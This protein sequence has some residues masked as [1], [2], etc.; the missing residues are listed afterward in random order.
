MKN[1]APAVALMM[2][3]G[4][5]A[6]AP[7]ISVPISEIS[8]DDSVAPMATASTPA[9]SAWRTA[10]D[11]DRALRPQIP[12]LVSPPTPRVGTGI[13]LLGKGGAP[14]RY[15][16]FDDIAPQTVNASPTP[17]TLQYDRGP[18][19]VRVQ[20]LLDRANFST[21]VID[22][23]MAKNTQLAIYWFQYSQGL[24]PTGVINPETYNRLATVAGTDRV[25]APSIIDQQSLE[26][27]FVR[28][29]QSVYAQSRLECMCYS[30]P[31]ELLAERFHTTPEVL[32]KLNPQTGFASLSAG[33]FIWAP[34][35][36]P[37]QNS[38]EKPVA[39]IHISK[40]GNYVQA[41]AADGSIVLHFPS[42]LGSMYDPSPD[43]KFEVIGVARYPTF[44]YDPKL[45]S[46]VP[47]TKP[48]AK[49]PP[50]P[51]SPVGTVWIALSK[52]HVGIHGTPTPETIGSASSHGCVRLTNWDAEKL[53]GATSEG[54]PVE[55]VL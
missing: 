23:H 7:R 39:R 46:D 3:L 27:P 4:A 36:Q 28:I 10:A 49:L 53:A 34:S 26:G 54:T 20:V 6:C 29:P 13:E 14:V 25:I 22:G 50:G 38:Q 43:G 48:K 31:I 19:V 8:P 12:A 24:P 21:G 30:S 5:A 51:N 41:L 17:E 16:D 37:T 40:S 47:D 35:V 33:T 1:H 55:F 32:R 44:A 45:F 15:L 2:I 52:E 18:A 11:R 42:T 9:T